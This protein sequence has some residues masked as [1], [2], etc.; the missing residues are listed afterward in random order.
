MSINN[1]FWKEE[2]SADEVWDRWILQKKYKQLLLY[3]K[4]NND[5]GGYSTS[6]YSS[7]EQALL[8]DNKVFLFKQFWKYILGTRIKRFW[9]IYNHYLK[10]KIN[11]PKP[12]EYFY[13]IDKKLVEEN[14]KKRS[15]YRDT[16]L[17]MVATWYDA[18]WHIEK[19]IEAMQ[20]INAKE[21]IE[22]AKIIKQSIY[23]LKKPKAKKTTDKRKIDDVLF[24]GLIQEA[25]NQTEDNSEFLELLQ[26]KLE[27]FSATEIKKFKKHFLEKMNE[28][29]SWDIWA[30]AYIV[31][32]G[33]GDDGFDY[34][35]A[36]V[37]S[38]GQ[39]TFENVKDLKLETLQ[40]IFA[41][42]EPQ[43]E[44]MFYVANEAYENK[45]SE[46]MPQPRVKSQQIMGTQW[47]EESICE[48]YP[49]L[50]ELFEFQVL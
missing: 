19:H 24:W 34:F 50:C 43:L 10:S 20:K 31:R 32:Q 14:E 36:W 18:L 6:S 44:E 12:I 13:N 9:K 47:S 27:A 1:E 21:E 28:L 48:S 49:K 4:A 25:Q 7:L 22:K 2:G 46:E 15:A 8:N 5:T 38:K 26:N 16:N 40:S 29:Y 17:H 23:E 33:C 39:E 41:Q 37:I 30:L 45:K 42:E 11:T 35:C 3:T